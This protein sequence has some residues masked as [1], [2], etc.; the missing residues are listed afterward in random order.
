MA[1]LRSPVDLSPR[2][3]D[4]PW[5]WGVDKVVATLCDFN[6]PMLRGV[7][8]LSIPDCAFLEKALR[9]NAVSGP[10]LLTE[11]THP[12]LR[13]DL[14]LR[15]LGH[16]T[17]V[18]HIIYELRRQSARYYHHLQTN[19]A[20]P[21]PT[22]YGQMLNLG[23]NNPRFV[24]PR[25]GAPF[26]QISREASVL[27]ENLPSSFVPIVHGH[28]PASRALVQ[29]Y[30]APNYQPQPSYEPPRGSI[31]E[32]ELASPDRQALQVQTITENENQ[33]VDRSMA[34]VDDDV[35]MDSQR[36]QSSEAIGLLAPEK[37]RADSLVQKI[38]CPHSDIG[39][40]GETVIID[41]NGKKRRRL[42]LT[43]LEHGGITSEQV[44][45]AA[46]ERSLSPASREKYPTLD[47]DTGQDNRTF[48]DEPMEQSGPSTP[49][50]N[51][52]RE[53]TQP[54]PIIK[55]LPKE[56]DRS[57]TITIDQQGRKR[58]KPIL[59]TRSEY[60]NS[61]KAV[62]VAQ[63]ETFTGSSTQLPTSA[64][65][66]SN[67]RPNTRQ[68]KVQNLRH[69]YLGTESLPIDKL[70]Y[71][72]TKIGQEVEHDIKYDEN[73]QSSISD[74]V[75]DFAFA[76]TD[77]GNGQRCYVNSRIR[78]FLYSRKTRIIKHRGKPMVLHVPYPDSFG[79]KHHQLSVTV[80]SES[81]HGIIASRMDR[82][83][84][85]G[86]E[87]KSREGHVFLETAPSQ[88]NTAL[89][90][91]ET[92]GATNWD[93]LKKWDFKAGEENILPVYGDSGSENE[94]DIDTWRE[95][96]EEGGTIARPIGRS[97]RKKLD[98]IAV[99]HAIGEAMEHIVERWTSDKKPKLL[100]KAW[101]IWKKAR[102]DRTVIKEI[103]ALSRHVQHLEAR[104]SNIKNEI[105]REDWSS[106]KDVMKQCKSMEESIFDRE[107]CNWKVS[108]LDL[109]TVPEKPP[110]ATKK[111]KMPKPASSQIP[112]EDSGEDIVS[113]D[114]ASDSSDDE[115]DDF[116]DD[117]GIDE[118]NVEYVNGDVARALG[119]PQAVRVSDIPDSDVNDAS[120]ESD[121][122]QSQKL[123]SEPNI[124]G[125]KIPV[126]TRRKDV[127]ETLRKIGSN[128]NFEVIDLTQQSECSEAETRVE[129]SSPIRTPP[130]DS[131]PDE[132][133]S[134]QSPGKPAVFKLPPIASSVIQV[135]SDSAEYS[136]AKEDILAS[137]P[138]LP[139][140]GE[141]G[142]ISELNW[143]ILVE[144]KDRKRLL[145]WIVDH[146]KQK[147]RDLVIGFFN[148]KPFEDIEEAVW[149]A[150][151]AL[152]NKNQKQIRDFA[153]QD[154]D[155]W[156]MLASWYVCW[157]IPVRAAW[158]RGISRPHLRTAK[159]DRKGFSPFY[160]FLNKCLTY[161]QPEKPTNTAAL[162]SK[163]QKSKKKK[164]R[165]LREGSDENIES[166]PHKKRKF[167]VP[168]SQEAINLRQKAHERVR[169][170]D[171]RQNHL[172]R[173][174]R[175]M[176]ANEEDSRIAVVN[177]GKLDDQEFIY[178]NPK[179]SSKM[180]P[181][182]KE[183][184]QFMWREVITDHQGC[185]LAQ[186]MGLGKTM[187]V[188]TL[189][190]TIA[191]AARS[192][193]ENVR[194]QVPKDLHQSRTLILCPPAL[195]E[196]WWEE[197]LM[198]T[199]SPSTDNVGVPRKI[200]AA[201]KLQER[202]Y[203][204][205]KWK[206]DGGVLFLGF[207]TFRN[208]VQN[209]SSNST[210]RVMD[211]DQHKMI[212][213]ALLNRPNLIVAD[214]AHCAKS[215]TSGINQSIN[216]FK[217]MNRIAL[218]G[219]P[220]ANNL[221]EY[222]TLIDWIAPNYLGTRVEFKANYGER[223]QEGLYQDSTSSQYRESLKLLEVLKTEL[224]PKVH[225]ADITVLRGRL[226]EKQEFVIRVPLTQL[227]NQIYE[228]YV[229]LMLS[230]SRE[231]EP[232]SVTMWAWLST[233]R[234][235]CNHPKCF[236]NKLLSKDAAEVK[237]RGQRK[238][239]EK[240]HAKT[241]SRF[242][243]LE[244]LDNLV[245]AP[246][247]EIGISQS[248]AERQLAPFNAVVEP[249]DSTA[250]SNKMQILMEIIKFSREV[251]DKVLVFSHS[252]QTLNYVEEKMQE[253]KVEYSRIDGMVPPTSRQNITKEFNSGSIEVCL[254]STRAGG[255]GLNLFGANR[256]I[257]LDDHFN[258]MYEEQAV[259]RAYRI[260]QKKAVFVYHLTAGGTFEDLLHNQSVFKQQ[261]ARRVVDK[262]NPARYAS[263]KI[264]E[265][266]FH[267]KNLEQKD[268]GE[269]RGKDP[270]VL[271]RILNEHKKYVQHML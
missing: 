20:I 219:S 51:R 107:A 80:Y 258:P 17:T 235:L 118:A 169:E 53:P 45:P 16:R 1:F 148:N 217:S 213:D 26:Q 220:L 116:I 14:G 34:M 38:H 218:T 239:N 59:I 238:T 160:E 263:R 158:E 113:K 125:Q 72:D 18:M 165:E 135:D 106:T 234:L 46:E 262:K 36:A 13:D 133:P 180:Q 39:R 114:S 99:E 19:N 119:D 170:R 227:Q 145:I 166:T 60:E 190:V 93:Y 202:L 52:V 82:S 76:G 70:F 100:L 7:D 126:E 192:P 171:M 138:S 253:R 230:V 181:H 200:T 185:L 232:Q 81:T 208:L 250:L 184:V 2:P 44:P 58:L 102:K 77:F 179:I 241:V 132:D 23:H 201:I 167:A 127:V 243:A 98:S 109:R 42:V 260:G 246:V 168:E 66:T 40:Q 49:T 62:A 197:F 268:L 259:G 255:Q 28:Q 199:P 162:N 254:I 30:P 261:L 90:E 37:S 131:I 189:L 222:H 27:S 231:D 141:V 252:I 21:H 210:N 198:W 24:P 143:E 205:E 191:E 55:T 84:C 257:I 154:S 251:R 86:R 174:F 115:L 78:H 35:L 22:G 209:K 175:E 247:S 79:K 92:E 110:P 57:G 11:L 50:E 140:F 211:V 183:G 187:Q 256:V 117:E 101:G 74:N 32:F 139:E 207:N 240:L 188:I 25:I 233:L 228:I 226:K 206:D 63:V 112:V 71:S 5:F 33:D 249:H 61:A 8:P 245:D 146:A 47:G 172:K 156:M 54:E 223:I 123:K 248:M 204:I 4:D 122:M 215:I 224:Q 267:P 221:E 68:Q 142:K 9:E 182:Q 271:D 155:A 89:L 85:F 214:E 159:K 193:N 242:D 153:K 88:P 6:A 157:T 31:Q 15:P 196:N 152:S 12:V 150:F 264:G 96:E 195:V 56:D 128:S 65:E 212:E 103:S 97:M 43:S 151:K 29:N 144:R 265:Y 64:T 129:Q 108:I 225:R 229:D 136:T 147:F 73:W 177:P 3:V 216:R 91:I 269:F 87:V 10:T 164:R 124:P 203:E 161:Y 105:L 173:R 137:P 236:Q 83:S 178:I 270:V 186:T 48:L 163:G 111:P 237:V 104:L 95:M 69:V 149:M 134:K 194:N 130:V 121:D 266:L 244:E 67:F 176:G 120:S 41:E 75:E 94:Y